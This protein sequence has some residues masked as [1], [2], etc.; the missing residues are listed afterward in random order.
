VGSLEPDSPRPPG[1]GARARDRAQHKP[2]RYRILAEYL[3]DGAP[4]RPADIRAGLVEASNRLA[5][6]RDAERAALDDISAWLRAASDRVG[7]DGLTL[8]EAI[9]LAGI[10][11]RTAYQMLGD[12]QVSAAPSAQ[13]HRKA[14]PL[15]PVDQTGERGRLG[16]PGG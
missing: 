5:A 1:K 9:R 6:A 15:D 12:D 10:S 4:V 8:S 3:A 2:D 13:T 14:P 16:R 7:R 11:R